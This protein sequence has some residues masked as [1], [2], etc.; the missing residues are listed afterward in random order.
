M[1]GAVISLREI[2]RDAPAGLTMT[3]VKQD[4][5]HLVHPKIDPIHGGPV[6]VVRAQV[7]HGSKR[8]TTAHEKNPVSRQARQQN[9]NQSKPISEPTE[10]S[11]T[12]LCP[13]NR[14]W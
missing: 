14:V 11:D 1:V 8:G 6:N 9:A 7:K 13:T 4:R 2:E 5:G 10:P 12:F 3:T